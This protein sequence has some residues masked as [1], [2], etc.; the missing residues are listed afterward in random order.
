MMERWSNGTL[1]CWVLQ[2][3]AYFHMPNPSLHYFTI[4]LFLFVFNIFN[5]LSNVQL[6]LY[7]LSISFPML[8]VRRHV[9]PNASETLANTGAGGG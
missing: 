8:K 2:R 7:P 1:E 6:P 3:E 4:P 5:F 9:D